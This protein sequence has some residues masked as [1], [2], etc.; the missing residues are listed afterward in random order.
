MASEHV[1]EQGMQTRRSM[2]SLCIGSKFDCNGSLYE[3]IPVLP[4]GNILRICKWSTNAG[5]EL[6]LSCAKIVTLVN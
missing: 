3:A 5:T 1:N 2:S 4:K 6:I